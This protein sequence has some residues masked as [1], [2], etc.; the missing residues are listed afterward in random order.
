M[1]ELLN[2]QKEAEFRPNMKF[3]LDYSDDEKMNSLGSV[4]MVTRIPM[5]QAHIFRCSK[6]E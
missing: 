4:E 2:M 5:E 1:Y 3:I 6:I